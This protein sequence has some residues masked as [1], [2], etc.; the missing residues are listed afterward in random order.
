MSS[1]LPF[2]VLLPTSSLRSPLRPREVGGKLKETAR[3]SI[4]TLMADLGIVRLCSLIRWKSV[5]PSNGRLGIMLL[6]SSLP[7]CPPPALRNVK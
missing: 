6:G 5:L 1:A 3:E 7:A 2:P 4:R